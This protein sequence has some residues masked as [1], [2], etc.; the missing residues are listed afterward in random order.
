MIEGMLVCAD[1]C[2]SDLVKAVSGHSVGEPGSLRSI[3]CLDYLAKI[4]MMASYYAVPMMV[5]VEREVVLPVGSI[6]VTASVTTAVKLLERVPVVMVFV[7]DP[8]RLLYTLLEL[9]NAKREMGRVIV[10]L[11]LEKLRDGRFA[12]LIAREAEMR[13][14]QVL[15]ATEESSGEVLESLSPR[16]VIMYG[17]RVR[18]AELGGYRVRIVEPSPVVIVGDRVVGVDGVHRFYT[19]CSEMLDVLSS[20]LSQRGSERI[21]C[22]CILVKTPHGRVVIDCELIQFLNL[23]NAYKSMRRAA[24]VLGVAL[25]SIKRR[26]E[27]IEKLLNVKLVE[28]RRGGI[29]RGRSEITA[30]A[31]WLLEK[32]S[33]IVACSQAYEPS[34]S[35]EAFNIFSRSLA[36][37]GS[38]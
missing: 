1:T 14:I 15:I 5:Y 30:Y 11:K 6:A 20:I 34:Y 23:V 19:S 7:D 3:G 8:G 16:P 35:D 37:S 29:E 18:V 24:S 36:E 17:L 2:P 10:L 27:K 12:G 25:S 4:S 32:Y 13:G 26:V 33:R 28:S 38:V 22:P 31:R 9:S 21:A